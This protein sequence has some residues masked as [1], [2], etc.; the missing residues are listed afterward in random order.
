MTAS[1][2]GVVKNV[3]AEAHSTFSM[4]GGR[5]EAYEPTDLLPAQVVN[6]LNHTDGTFKSDGNTMNPVQSVVEVGNKGAFK[7]DVSI[8]D[9]SGTNT[10]PQR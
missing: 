10:T 1:P 5:V 7:L 3:K 8:P 4:S 9:L 2:I 6:A